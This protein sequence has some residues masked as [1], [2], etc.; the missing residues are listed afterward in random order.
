[1]QRTG[2]AHMLRSTAWLTRLLDLFQV[3]VRNAVKSGLMG[4]ISPKNQ[5]KES[6]LM[7]DFKAFLG[8]TR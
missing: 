7:I 8:S 4:R 3:I 1:M 6:P 2:A 5:G